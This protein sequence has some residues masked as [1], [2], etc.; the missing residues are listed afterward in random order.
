MHTTTGLPVE[1][2]LKM[3]LQTCCV[4]GVPFAMPADLTTQR[5]DDGKSFHCP[6]GHS[7][8]YTNNLQKQ[9]DA[10]NKVIAEKDAKLHAEAAA[11]ARAQEEAKRLQKALDGYRTP[12][13]AIRRALAARPGASAQEIATELGVPLA[14]VTNTKNSLRPRKPKSA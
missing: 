4:C 11:L 5:R 2:A 9:L 8:S 10:A 6:N 1:C 14:R 12:T 3:E 13:S 7:Q